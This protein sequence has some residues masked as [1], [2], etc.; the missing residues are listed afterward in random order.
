MAYTLLQLVDQCSGELGL[1]QPSAVIGSSVNQTVQFL[2]LAQRL[3]KDLVRE[4]EWQRLVKEYT[5]QTANG[6]E[7][8]ALPSDFDRMVSDTHW[9][10]DNVWPNWGPKTSQEWQQIKA[11][12]VNFGRTRFRL[13][14]N[15]LRFTPTPTSTV[16]MA[17]EYVSNL[18]V[19]AT[20]GTVAT[21]ATF[22][23]DSDFTIFPDDLMLAGLKYYFLKAKKLDFGVELAEYSEI[24][25]TRKAQDVPVS[26]QSVTPQMPDELT[27][28][29]PEGGWSL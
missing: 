1:S 8:Y 24:L 28:T 13:Y 22:T 19:L 6:T 26:Q 4:F 5:F 12:L 2:A 3:G 15:S 10:R 16:D 21:K 18:W 9:D 14:Q 7:D 17:Y 29:I 20:G 25:S 23:V 27:T 11:G